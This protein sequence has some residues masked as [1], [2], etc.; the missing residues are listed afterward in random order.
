MFKGT[1]LSLSR[2][3][4]FLRPENSIFPW[5]ETHSSREH[6]FVCVHFLHFG[7]LKMWFLQ[8]WNTW[9]NLWRVIK[10]KVHGYMAF[11]SSF[12]AFW[13]PD[14]L[15]FWRVMKPTIQRNVQPCLSFY[16]FWRL[17]NAISTECE[18]RVS[19]LSAFWG[20]QK[21]FLLSRNTKGL[22]VPSFL[23]PH[24]LYL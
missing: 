1:S 7:V 6:T 20:I 14:N 19:P 18:G 21:R 13:K 2:F 24:F 16:A 8:S 5:R 22:R 4:S 10:P 15:Y 23:W 3:S 17:E 11:S 9:C 12:S